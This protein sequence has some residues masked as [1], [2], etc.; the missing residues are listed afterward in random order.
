MC[1]VPPGVTGGALISIRPEHMEIGPGEG[2]LVGEVVRAVY[3]GR[4][5]DYRIRVGGLELRVESPA[6]RAY[7]AGDRVALRVNQAM[8]FAL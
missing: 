1:A 8:V 3:L 5:V 7:Q 4:M 2:G 6:A